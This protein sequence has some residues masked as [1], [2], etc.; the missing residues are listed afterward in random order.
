MSGQELL[1][2]RH[3]KSSWEQADDHERDLTPRGIE[4][5]RQLGAWLAR[6]R[7]RPDLVLCS[8]ATRAQHTWQL[9]GE[10][11][12]D[13]LPKRDLP[14]LYLASADRLLEIVRTEG[15]SAARLL[16]VGHNP[17]L[18]EFASRV[19]GRG[20]PGALTALRT[21]FPTAALAHLRFEVEGWR[22]IDYELGELVSFWRPRDPA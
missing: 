22:A 10:A 7:L 17:G 11:L 13:M 19:S 6:N 18:G 15:G 5:A 21:K 14:A 4:A 2:L 1:L 12:P 3:A 16:M 20:D 9:A 8:T